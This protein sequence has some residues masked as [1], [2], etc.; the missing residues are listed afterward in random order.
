MEPITTIAS[1]AVVGKTSAATIPSLTAAHASMGSYLGALLTPSSIVQGADKALYV[2][3]ALDNMEQSDTALLGVLRVMPFSVGLGV[4][5]ATQG[6]SAQMLTIPKGDGTSSREIVLST[7][8]KPQTSTVTENGKRVEEQTTVVQSVDEK[9]MKFGHL[10]DLCKAITEGRIPSIKDIYLAVL[11]VADAIDCGIMGQK[12]TSFRIKD[13]IKEHELK[14]RLTTEDKTEIGKEVKEDGSTKEKNVEQY[15]SRQTCTKTVMT[16]LLVDGN[17]VDAMLQTRENVITKMTIQS[18]NKLSFLEKVFGGKVE[19]EVSTRTTAEMRERLERYDSDKGK[20]VLADEKQHGPIVSVIH[21]NNPAEWKSG[22]FSYVPVI[23]S[24]TDLVR[25]HGAGFTLTMGDYVSFG[26]D[27]AVSAVTFGMGVAG[28]SAGKNAILAGTKYVAQNKAWQLVPEAAPLA[29]RAAE[30]LGSHYQ[31]LGKVFSSERIAAKAASIAHNPMKASFLKGLLKLEGLEK[32][33]VN[34]RQYL[35]EEFAAQGKMGGLR[36]KNLE[37]QYRYAKRIGLLSQ[38]N[39]Q[40]MMHGKNP[41]DKLGRRMDID[42]VIPKSL[43][44][45]LKADPA[46]LR[47]LPQR[48][49]I[50]RSN[51]LDTHAMKRIRDFHEAMP[52]WLPQQR[53]IDAWP[54]S[55]NPPSWW[56]RA[57]P[58][59]KMP[60]RTSIPHHP[61]YPPLFAPLQPGDIPQRIGGIAMQ[62]F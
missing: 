10:Q 19:S 21:E 27:L 4:A 60:I 15:T 52:E 43:A 13:N 39:R 11:D 17:R 56:P 3:N 61:Q 1:A 6:T 2:C 54:D 37:A 8:N 49:N 9:Y 29:S 31:H 34:I 40:L 41:I 42:H 55:M 53:L 30:L 16:E 51:Q 28:A 7:R 32:Q 62:S 47:F 58:P 36:A 59:V 57:I 24:G 18:A 20:F 5:N 23:G 45:E 14:K 44:P 26:I 48:E 22:Y 25:K 46:N 35:K 12:I 33:G 50:A 38:E